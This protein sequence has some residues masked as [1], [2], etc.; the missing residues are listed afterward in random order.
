MV[1]FLF[2]EVVISD[3]LKDGSDAHIEGIVM[4]GRSLA[5]NC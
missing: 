4:P 1:V 3:A 5:L 2:L